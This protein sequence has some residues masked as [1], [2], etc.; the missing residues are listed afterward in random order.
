MTQRFTRYD[1]LKL[2]RSSDWSPCESIFLVN[3]SSIAFPYDTFILVFISKVSTNRLW[4]RPVIIWY[5]LNFDS[6]YFLWNVVRYHFGIFIWNSG[7]SFTSWSIR[8]EADNVRILFCGL[9]NLF[10]SFL[11][12]SI[13]KPNQ[14]IW[15][16]RTS[17]CGEVKSGFM[18][19]WILFIYIFNCASLGLC[20]AYDR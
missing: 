16:K 2:S 1:G 3:L 6:T 14:I 9:K 8:F 19:I 5:C 13:G 10:A 15:Q 20:H 17:T 7:F 18:L 4:G 12:V 11:H